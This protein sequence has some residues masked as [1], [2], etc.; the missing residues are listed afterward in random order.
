[1][2]QP[3]NEFTVDE[4]T[5]DSHGPVSTQAAPV[6]RAD[7]QE[8]SRN[9]MIAA[10]RLPTLYELSSEFNA[11]LALLEDEAQDEVAIQ[12]EL[13]RLAGDIRQKAYGIAVVLQTLEHMAELQSAE[14]KRLSNKA[15]SNQAHADRLRAYTLNVMQNTPGCE[16]IEAGFFT[17]AIRQNPYAVTVNDASLV[18][19]EFNRTKITVDVD[20][21][22]ILETFK[23][24]GEIPPGVSVGRSE[25]LDIK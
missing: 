1:M 9:F 8:A 4:F 16:R 23:S 24:T 5:V 15:K 25:R 18:P 14:A 22:A 2:S 11:L 13:E 6:Q 3:V 21:R 12:H 10:N 17:L 19:S 7:L 20:K